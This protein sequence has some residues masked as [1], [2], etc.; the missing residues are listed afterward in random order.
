MEVEG[1]Q[2]LFELLS[3]LQ[4]LSWLVISSLIEMQLSQGLKHSRYLAAGQKVTN[5]I[6]SIWD[7]WE[8]LAR[9]VRALGL[10][11]HSIRKSAT[12]FLMTP[13]C[14]VSCSLFRKTNSPAEKWPLASCLGHWLHIESEEMVTPTASETSFQAAHFSFLQRCPIQMQTV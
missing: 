9:E 1:L 11:I 4:K 2:Y 8:N 12:E 5:N 14:Q 10:N 3:S 13:S 7:C 6:L